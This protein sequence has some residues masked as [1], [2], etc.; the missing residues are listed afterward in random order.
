MFSILLLF[1]M[2]LPQ[3]QVY[4]N[5]NILIAYLYTTLINFVCCLFPLPEISSQKAKIVACLV[6]IYISGDLNSA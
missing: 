5:K 1:C 3:V 4:L 2:V 6:Y